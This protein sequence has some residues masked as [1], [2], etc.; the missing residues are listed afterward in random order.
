MKIHSTV[1]NYE[2]DRYSNVTCQAESQATGFLAFQREVEALRRECQPRKGRSLVKSGEWTVSFSA[3][4]IPSIVVTIREAM[5]AS[6]G[7]IVSRV[8]YKVHGKKA[9]RQ[10]LI[11]LFA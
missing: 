6:A 9:T 4:D 11:Q 1:I 2:S 8:T 7:M 10:S 3:K 5:G